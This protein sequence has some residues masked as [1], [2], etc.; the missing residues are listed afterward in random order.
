[1]NIIGALRVFF[2]DFLDREVMD[3]FEMPSKSA[4][5]TD[6]P[7]KDDLQTFYNALENPQ[8]QSSVSVCGH[9]RTPLKRTLSADDGRY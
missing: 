2:R 3:A 7:S 5:P 8:V 1:M 9:V 6:V 4:K